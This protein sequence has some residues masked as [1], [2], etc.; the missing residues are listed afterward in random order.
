[1]LIS[2]NIVYAYFQATTTELSSLWSR[3]LFILNIF[4]KSD[5][6]I[7]TK[8]KSLAQVYR[9]SKEGLVVYLYLLQSYKEALAPEYNH[10]DL[11]RD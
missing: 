1:M 10:L 5:E 8:V 4:F 9:A 3:Y 6:E 2:L 11:A 7:E